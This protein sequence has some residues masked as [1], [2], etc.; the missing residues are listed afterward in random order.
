MAK[1]L[2]PSA[3]LLRGGSNIRRR[4]REEVSRNL[5]VPVGWEAS[6]LHSA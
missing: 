6:S 5:V 2:D 1:A 4:R 3:K